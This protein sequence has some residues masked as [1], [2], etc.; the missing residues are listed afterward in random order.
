MTETETETET[1]TETDTHRRQAVSPESRDEMVKLFHQGYGTRRIA[2]R[3]GWSRKIVRA[4]LGTA[5]CRRQQPPSRQSKLEPFRE[6]VT[7][8]VQQGLRVTRILREL[9]ELGYQGGRTILAG[10]VQQ[11]RPQLAL[12]PR[13]KIKRRFETPPG[14]ELQIDWSPFTVDIGGRPTKVHALAC[15]LCYSR[16]L[17]LGFFRNER[18]P[19]LLEGLALCFEYLDGCALRLVLDNMA[20]AVVGRLAGGKVLWHPRFLD[21][22]RHYAVE[23]RACAVRDPDRKGKDE[24]I[25]Q[26]I[27]NDLLKGAA[28]ASWD[29]LHERTTQWL[30]HTPGVAN[31]RVHGTTRRVPNEAY[32]EEHEF[33]IRLPRERFPV[34]EDA[35]RLV[36][37]DATLSICGTKYSVPAALATRSVAVRLYA[38]HFEVLDPHGRIALSRRYVADADKGKLILDP[39]HYA[40]LPRRPR[41]GGG[42]G[43][44]LDAAFLRRFPTLALLADGLKRRFKTLAPVHF[45]A[46]LR[47]CDRFGEPAFVAAA[48]RAQDYHRFD[49]PAIT[50]I[51]EHDHPLPL[52]AEPVPPLGGVGPAVLGEVEPASLDGYGRLDGAAPHGPADATPDPDA[53]Q[54]QADPPPDPE[55]PHGP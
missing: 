33:L 31:L 18:Q 10:H 13:T 42:S 15:L 36:D 55:D 32:R 30:D 21:F 3:V 43:E 49:A 41:G 12:A 6:E 17:Y 23:P 27:E 28:F 24:K 2:E 48:T 54:P 34:W 8:R 51:L 52:E 20:T 53:P 29:D 9:R 11:L 40:L 38:A 44:R 39:T 22:V 46:L 35:I 14:K 50:R 4:V 37:Q 45:R 5:G 19:T 7:R 47:L 26:L 1:M 16:K 25:F